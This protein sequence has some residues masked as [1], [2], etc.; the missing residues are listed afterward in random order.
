MSDT[1]EQVDILLVEDNALDAE[2]AMRALE[3][4]AVANHVLWIK[5][6]QQA[7]DYLFCRGEYQ[8]RSK[9]LPRLVLLDLKMPRVD[10]MEVLKAIKSDQRTRRIAVVIMTSSQEEMDLARSYDLGANSY[11]VKPV[12]F[13][14]FAD[15]ARQAGYYWLAVNRMPPQIS[16]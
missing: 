14:A 1:Y 3:K 16:P 2:L 10:G 9:S 5:D 15:V 13:N 12:D 4:G 11:I 6:G 7:L 8:D